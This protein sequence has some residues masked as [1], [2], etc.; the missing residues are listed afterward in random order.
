M[1]KIINKIL[2]SLTL[3]FLPLIVKAQDVPLPN[4][5]PAE[6]IPSLISYTI[7][8]ILGVVGAIALLMLVWGGI[9]WMTSQGS[10]DRVKRGRETI[11]WAVFGL[12]VIFLSYAIVK[13]VLERLQG[14]Q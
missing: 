2:T 6:D 3:L 9:T 7:R 1:K 8:G 4:P 10:S 12:A 5:L 13:F 14:V 11:T